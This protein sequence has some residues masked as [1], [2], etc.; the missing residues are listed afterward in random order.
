ML[1]SPRHVPVLVIGAG[2]A[3]LGTSIALER[4]GVD[5]VVLES[6]DDVGG[7]WRDNR[8]P[9]CKCDVP[10]HLYSFSFAL[11][12]EWSST[13]SSQPEIWAYLRR[14]AERFG[15]LPRIRFGTRVLEAC[16]VERAQR[17]R[18]DTSAGRW[19]ADVVVTATGGLSVP[20]V[21]DLPGLDRFAGTVFH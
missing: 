10:S 13:Y 7:T 3:G 18:V 2:F 1:N 6:A 16:W 21:P 12:P 11:N 4:E 5:H 9:G 20:A 19:T 14:C 17:W 8:Y 15:V